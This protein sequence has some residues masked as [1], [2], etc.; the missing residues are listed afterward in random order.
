MSTIRCSVSEGGLK[1]GDLAI[2]GLI[3]LGGLA[4][5]GLGVKV[6]IN[7]KGGTKNNIKNSTFNGPYAGRDINGVVPKQDKEL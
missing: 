5:L 2:Y 6:I 3:V 4:V 7:I 1:L